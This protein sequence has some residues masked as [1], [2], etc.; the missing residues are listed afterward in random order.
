MSLI[1]YILQSCDESLRYRVTF[2]GATSLNVSETWFV[3]CGGIQ[4]GCYQVLDDTNEVLEEYNSDECTFVEF[5]V[6]E[7]RDWETSTNI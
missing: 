6:C 1:K 7:D 4:S 3:E 2:T 5:D